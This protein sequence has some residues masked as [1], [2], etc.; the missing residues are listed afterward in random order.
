M[1][2][3][4]KDLIR[5]REKQNLT[6]RQAADFTRISLRHLQNLEE[7]RYSELPGGMY[8]RAF[9]RTYCEYLGL[10]PKEIL[11]R[12]DAETIPQHEKSTKSK[13][14]VQ[15]PSV[16]AKSHALLV[17]AVMLCVSVAGLY[18]SRRWIFR[19]FSPYFSPPASIETP[20]LPATVNVQPV[21]LSPPV[22]QPAVPASSEVEKTP[23]PPEQP[24]QSAPAAAQA[25]S[26]PLPSSVIRIEV[27]VVQ[28]CWVSVQGDGSTV[29]S[30]LLEPGDD[31][32]FDANE[33]FYIV[34]GNAGGIR[35]KINGKPA[36]PLGKPGEVAR[37]LIN[38]HNLE[39]FV[40]KA[41][42]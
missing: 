17:W 34:L 14:K 3:L 6:L 24:E 33:R 40:E 26:T 13:T 12:Y 9:L 42:H 25:T 16:P 28:K 11:G 15:P 18:F 35:L 27:Q 32:S 29:L 38:Q 30:K 31:Q 2:P 8:N 7:A 1:E 36:K 41:T 22:S 23:P 4:G 5:A 39:D 19:I 21:P 10:E 37:V 20:R